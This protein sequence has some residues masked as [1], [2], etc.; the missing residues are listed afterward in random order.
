MHQTVGNRTTLSDSVLSYQRPFLSSRCSYCLVTF[1]DFL[2]R[3]SFVSFFW[4]PAMPYFALTC[5]TLVYFFRPSLAYFLIFPTFYTTVFQLYLLFSFFFYLTLTYF[6][7]FSLTFFFYF[8]FPFHICFSAC[9]ISPCF[10]IFLCNISSSRCFSGLLQLSRLCSCLDFAIFPGNLTLSA[11][12]YFS[13]YF[14]WLW[15]HLIGAGKPEIASAYCAQPLQG[16]CNPAD[17]ELLPR[18]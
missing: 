8:F 11:W 1:H 18:M 4:F 2:K 12:L 3:S 10:S 9:I 6:F 5:S 15:S 13:S 7:D 16:A 17:Q 14:L